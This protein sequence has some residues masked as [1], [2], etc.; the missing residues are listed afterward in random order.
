MGYT[1]IPPL[2]V[3]D[4]IT[5]EPPTILRWNID[6]YNKIA[7]GTSGSDHSIPSDLKCNLM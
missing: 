4:F 7:K 6:L 3:N 5:P 2:D 1:P